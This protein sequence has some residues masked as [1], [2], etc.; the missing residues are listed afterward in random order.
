MKTFKKYIPSILLAFITVVFT[1][2][3]KFIDVNTIGPDGSAVGFSAVNGFFRTLIG[4]NLTLYTITDWLGIIPIL[5]ILLYAGVGLSQLIKRKS[6][7]KV[8]KILFVLG[9]FY[10]ITGLV[11]IFFEKIIINYRPFIV[12]ETLEASYPS[13]HTM[14]TL[15]LCASSILVSKYF[16]SEKIALVLNNLAVVMAT[17]I[18]LGRFIS[19]VHWF[20]DII[21][22]LLFS[23]TLVSFLNLGLK[24][25]ASSSAKDSPK[26]SPQVILPTAA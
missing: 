23:A 12:E 19:G 26:Q 6:L 10:V 2:A 24:T 7:A 11:Y 14:I 18:V 5:S 9:A 4:S 8:D 21:G 17:A 15:C 20:T 1:L 13:S 25:I 16:F 3:V 22:G